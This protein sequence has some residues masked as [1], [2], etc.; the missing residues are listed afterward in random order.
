MCGEFTEEFPAQMASNAENVSISW[1]HHDQ[2][3]TLLA[4]VRSKQ[5]GPASRP[6]RHYA[7]PWRRHLQNITDF[8][9]LKL[10]TFSDVKS[11]GKYWLNFVFLTSREIWWAVSRNN[12]VLLSYLLQQIKEHLALF[13]HC[14]NSQTRLTIKDIVVHL[15]WIGSWITLSCNSPPDKIYW[16][17]KCV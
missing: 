17:R 1:R 9:N 10:D 7:T 6:W 12:T 16:Y 5:L 4:V 13:C 3:L 14:V 11:K 2:Q 8:R 15:Y